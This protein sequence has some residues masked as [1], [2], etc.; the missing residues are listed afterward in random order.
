MTKSVV[1]VLGG[2]SLALVLG[3]CASGKK[4]SASLVAAVDR[5]RR[6]EI[7]AK[8]P[9]ADAIA[10][11]PCTDEAVCAAKLACVA[12]AGPTVKGAALKAE[13]ERAL[14]DLRSGK[15]TQDAAA[16]MG[17]PQKLD[18]ASSLLSEGEGKL[19]RCDALITALRLK[20]AL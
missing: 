7:G 12:S 5:Y 11:A 8:G 15:L 10:D 16:Q 19:G 20:Y 17:L 4:E 9:L 13:V 6:A 18:T 1:A 2:L 14:A 3:A